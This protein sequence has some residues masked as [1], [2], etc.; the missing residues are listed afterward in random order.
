MGC[1]T[2]GSLGRPA[3]AAA[4]TTIAMA[5]LLSTPIPPSVSAFRPHG[6][7]RGAPARAGAPRPRRRAASSSRRRGSGGEDSAAA[8]FAAPRAAP[9]ASPPPSPSPSSSASI[10]SG[11][12]FRLRRIDHVVV[13]CRTM[14]PMF[15]FYH[16]VLGCTVDEPRGAHVDRFG[17]ALTHLRAGSCYVDLLSYDEDRLTEEGREA[18]ARMHA[19][20]AGVGSLDDV[21]FSAETSTLDHLCLRVEP[22]DRQSLM[23][24]LEGERVPIVAAGD[25]RLGADG[26]GPSVYVR[27]PEGNVIELK[28]PPRDDDAS[29][30][31][32]DNSAEMSQT[33]QIRRRHPPES[34]DEIQTKE[35]PPQSTASEESIHTTKSSAQGCD[36]TD[37]PST[38]CVRICRYNSSFYDGRVCIGCFREAYEIETWQS[39]TPTQKSMTLL[40][41]I[42]RSPAGDCEDEED[43]TAEKFDGA[44]TFREL[45]RQHRFWTESANEL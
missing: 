32:D 15:D 13:R 2:M 27:D 45:K 3:R 30:A 42:D 39:M 11:P 44:I 10:D 37:V 35:H 8:S 6:G 33:D 18:A 14:P 19:G 16:R 40:D 7:N 43:L 34:R 20:G 17:G 9:P 22:F 29:N 31:V 12:P 4:V 23:D 41:A 1:W 21:H 26:V 36:P 38:P 25:G 28:G 5:S 24:Y